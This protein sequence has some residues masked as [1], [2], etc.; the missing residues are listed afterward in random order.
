VN[1]VS[2]AATIHARLAGLFVCARA[3]YNL[4]GGLASGFRQ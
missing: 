1:V 4:I 3:C 2:A